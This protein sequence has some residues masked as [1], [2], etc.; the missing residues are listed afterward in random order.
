MRWIE[1]S[2]IIILLLGCGKA[3]TFDEAEALYQN[4]E[5]RDQAYAAF[6]PLAE[7]G[8]Y[9]AQLRLGMYYLQK[10]PAQDF[11][12][13]ASYF[14]RAA[15]QGDID[16]LYFVGSFYEDGE[17]LPKNLFLAERYWLKAAE[18]GSYMAMFSLARMHEYRSENSRNRSDELRKAADWYQAAFIHGH[19]PSALFLWGLFTSGPL[20]DPLEAE[21]WN[22]AYEY[23]AIFEGKTTGSKPTL[24][25]LDDP[26]FRE[27]ARLLGLSHLA[28]YARKK[29]PDTFLSIS[30]GI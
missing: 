17:G 21:A 14:M 27:K 8:D 4:K 15:E 22:Y 1:I 20:R 10:G 5:T 29:V 25:S 16:A 30:T 7:K 6:R 3:L 13:S 11:V 28:L 9:R 26:I 12:K 23:A 18:G 19:F 2:L 24:E